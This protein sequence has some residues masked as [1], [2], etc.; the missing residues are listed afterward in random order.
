MIG[1]AKKSGRKHSNECQF[2]ITLCEIKTFDQ[3][4]V[5]FGRI[6]QG[7]DLIKEISYA[8]TYM[9]KPLVK[10]FIVK[11]GEYKF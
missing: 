9:Q 6:I 10:S 7:Y 1:M 5:A 11:S 8:E 4:F 2:Y 3:K